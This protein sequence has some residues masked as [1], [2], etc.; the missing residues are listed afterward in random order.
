MRE[1]MPDS[2]VVHK[3]TLPP[4]LDC[5]PLMHQLAEMANIPMARCDRMVLVLD[6]NDLPRLYV[7][8]HLGPAPEKLE[9]AK[10]GSVQPLVVD[11]TTMVNELL[12]TRVALPKRTDE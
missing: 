6:V 1:K 11:T 10:I 9:K 4:L 3:P 7:S 5:V 12:N 2:V 8:S